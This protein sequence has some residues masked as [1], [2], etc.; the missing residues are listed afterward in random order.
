MEKNK[1]IFDYI[2]KKEIS[3]P[4][5]SYFEALAKDVMKKNE[6]KIIPFYKK[7]ATWIA[8]AATLILSLL[9]VQ[10]L[11]DDDEEVNVLAEL[12]TISDTELLAY[13]DNNIDE[14]DAE[15]IVE[16]FSEESLDNVRFEI[17]SSVDEVSSESSSE[18]VEINFDGIE[19]DDILK[20]LEDEDID[21]DDLDNS[22]I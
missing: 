21:L 9:I 6:V 22:F 2:K 20:Y 18:E 17:N 12:D 3:T 16:S 8:V 7:P 19:V 5:A 10:N 4:D 15:M 11:G 14:F 13:I 1:D